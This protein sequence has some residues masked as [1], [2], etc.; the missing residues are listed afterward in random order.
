MCRSFPMIGIILVS[1]ICLAGV[2]PAAGGEET[3]QQIRVTLTP[4]HSLGALLSKSNIQL[5]DRGD[6]HQ[7]D[8]LSRPSITEELIRKGWTIRVIHPDLVA[9]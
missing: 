7:V 3:Y 8:V 4:K 1:L 2:A 5:M 9:Y 6:E